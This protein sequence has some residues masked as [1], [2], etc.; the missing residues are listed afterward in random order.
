MYPIIFLMKISRRHTTH[1]SAK[2]YTVLKSYDQNLPFF[3]TLPPKSTK[4]PSVQV[5]P[6]SIHANDGNPGKIASWIKPEHRSAAYLT[7]QSYGNATKEFANW[8]LLYDFP[9]FDIYEDKFKNLLVAIRGTHVFGPD[10]MQDLFDDF[11]IAKIIEG[12]ITLL[13]QV[14]EFLQTKIFP[15]GYKPSQILFT[16]HSLGGYV[17]LQLATIYA[18]RCAVFN[19]A[20][21]PLNPITHLGPGN[22]L[23]TCYHIVGD[24]ISSHISDDQ[25]EVL[26]AYKGSDFK[27]TIF[28]HSTDRF[29]ESDPT[30]DFYTA[31]DE[32]ILWKL[33][34]FAAR[35]LN[36]D[37][38]IASIP[39][40]ISKHTQTKLKTIHEGTEVFLT[41]IKLRGQV[42]FIMEDL[43]NLKL[44][45]TGVRLK[46]ST[47]GLKNLVRDAMGSR[48][49]GFNFLYDSAIDEIEKRE[50]N[51]FANTIED[52]LVTGNPTLGKYL[53]P[54]FEYFSSFLH[55]DD[56]E[57]FEKI[58]MKVFGNSNFKTYLDNRSNEVFEEKILYP[59][60]S[61]STDV[62]AKLEQTEMEEECSEKI[63][64][65]FMRKN[66]LQNLYPRRSS[67][68]PEQLVTIEEDLSIFKKIFRRVEY[69]FKGKISSQ[70]ASKVIEINRSV[71][72]N[73]IAC[74][75]KMVGWYDSFK[76]IPQVIKTFKTISKIFKPIKYLALGFVKAVQ[77]VSSILSW[78]N[79]VQLYVSNKITTVGK[80]LVN[81]T[82]KFGQQIGKL[83]FNQLEKSESGQLILRG[84]AT[85]GEFGGA[86]LEQVALA[87]SNPIIAAGIIVIDLYLLVSTIWEFKDDIVHGVNW[88]MDRASDGA[89]I[90]GK[91]IGSAY[92]YI[93]SVFGWG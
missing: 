33:F 93:K 4:P 90:I 39:G 15:L 88:I 68:N 17:A 47:D 78:F 34:T 38:P 69:F 53:D 21:P 91:S 92:S 89:S 50:V 42:A 83:I 41:A 84:L 64:E 13:Q 18:T 30:Y 63:C 54:H 75:E 3:P 66:N 31:G 12:Q 9:R 35:L 55:A 52:Y 85:V 79:N 25:V 61:S 67:S 62:I 24:G 45:A 7:F 82:T 22:L 71:V 70:D 29:F 56:D 48:N 26:R 36:P 2:R 44:I 14:Q 20:A 81:L 28:N 77:F 37:L 5:D 46:N 86:F 58:E 87:L 76:S 60:K 32:D 10:F 23:G 72:G 59:P 74:Y 73:S 43:N 27:N 16:G 80:A 51:A 6:I 1:H 19:P 57:I 49:L 40:D 8:S 65:R 11:I